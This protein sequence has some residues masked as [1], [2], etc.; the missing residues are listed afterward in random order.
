MEIK[1]AKSAGFCFGVDRAVNLV[2]DLLN[3]GEKVA[4]LGPIIHNNT[5]TEAI[6]KLGGIIVERVADCPKNYVLVGRSHSVEK[7]VYE[8]IKKSG[9]TFVDATCPFVTKIQNLVNE[10]HKDK[11]ILIAGDKDHPEVKSIHSFANY[12]GYTFDSLEELEELFHKHPDLEEKEVVAVAQ[13]TFQVKKWKKCASFLKKVCTN[14]LIFDT[15]CNATEKRQ[16]EALTL[17]QTADFMVVVGGRHSSNTQKLKEVC[18]QYCPTVLVETAAELQEKDFHGCKKVGVT[19][20]ASTPDAIIK[21]VLHTMNE[22]ATNNIDSEE[23]FDFEQALEAS[24]KPVHRNQRITGVVTSISANEVQVDIGTKHT[25]FIPL[26]ELSNDTSQKAE[27]LVQKGDELEL[28][29]LKVNDSEGTVMLS[30]KRFD[31][32]AGFDKLVKAHEEGT[33]LEGRITDILKGGVLAVAE[34]MKVFIP[35]S[36]V[37]LNRIEN[38]E[39]LKGNDVKFKIIDVDQGKKRAVASIKAV[40]SEEQKEVSDKFWEQ[41]D[42]G[43]TYNGV[44]KS[45]MPYGAFVDLGGVDGMVHI[46][47]LSW[48]KIKHPSEVVKVGDTVEVYVKDLDKENRKISLGHKKTD[49]NPWVVFERDYKLGDEVNAKIVSITSFG[50][51]AQILPGVDG[52]I[53]ISQIANQRVD[54][55]ANFLSVGEEVK[56]KLIEMDIENKRIS[57][58]IRALLEE[59]EV[60]EEK[61]IVDEYNE[62]VKAQEEAEDAKTAV[63]VTEETVEEVP[64]EESAE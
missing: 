1:L 49:D 4:T 43:Q 42:I 16:A 60:E 19:A 64:T 44:V 50:A 46:S 41:V 29:V 55:I 54:K 62:Q 6:E 52:L 61:S 59:E 58:S 11:T 31:S 8:E 63:E 39:E 28:I 9:L 30:K 10:H 26:S 27:N 40:L 37:S 56:A 18:L 17:A 25:G 47:E 38:L 48:V 33:V 57:L 32:I 12:N 23:E 14:A 34:G 20:G 13:T 35:A 53:H 45:I 15:I 51:F 5:V 24:L 21:E 2:Y 36:H 3:K 22:N 7:E